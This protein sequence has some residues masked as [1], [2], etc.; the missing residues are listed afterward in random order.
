MR[1][2]R[3]LRQ[4]SV[5]TRNNDPGDFWVALPGLDDKPL[6]RDS[7]SYLTKQLTHL[8]SETP[9][10]EHNGRASCRKGHG[11]SVTV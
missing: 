3:L 2:A 9:R 6:E 4:P 11:Q 1:P 8:S 7:I 5:V 10:T